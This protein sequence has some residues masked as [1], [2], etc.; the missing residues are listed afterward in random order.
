[1]SACGFV[2]GTSAPWLAASPD[3]LVLDF[4]QKEHEKGCL[5]VKCPLACEKITITEAC[6]RVSAFYLVEQSG[7]IH[8]SKSHGYYYQ[9]QTQMHV[10]T[11]KWCDFVVWSP[12]QDPFVQRVWYDPVFMEEALPKAILNSFCHQLF[13]V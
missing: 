6:R 2:V 7:D 12:L 10:T 11:L 3:R 8:L 4:T 5:E 9:I 1:M 13:H